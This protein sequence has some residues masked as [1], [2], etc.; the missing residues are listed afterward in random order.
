MSGRDRGDPVPGGLEW[1][2]PRPR[3]WCQYCRLRRCLESGLNLNLVRARTRDRERGAGKGEARK[4][5]R[6][7]RDDVKMSQDGVKMSQ[8]GVKISQNDVK[9]E[10][11]IQDYVKSPFTTHYIPGVGYNY[12]LFPGYTPSGGKRFISNYTPNGERLMPG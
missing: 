1:C 7:G 12:E 8:D 10:S 3:G 6:L 5:V 2:R 11:E 4:R 9:K